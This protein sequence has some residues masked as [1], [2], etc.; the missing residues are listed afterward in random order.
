MNKHTKLSLIGLKELNT[1]QAVYGIWR[2]TLICATLLISR[3]KRAYMHL[4]PGLRLEIVFHFKSSMNKL[5]NFSQ[6]PFN[7]TLK[8]LM[9]I[10]YVAINM[11]IM[12]ISQRL[13]ELLSN[14]WTM[15]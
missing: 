5:L 9:P 13:K 6:E 1:I 14:R 12:K 4:K 11:F 15:M 3:F 10:L 7:W 8:I 2:D